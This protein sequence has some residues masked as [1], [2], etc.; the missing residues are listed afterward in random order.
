M[1]TTK[2]RSTNFGSLERYDNAL[3]GVASLAERYFA[4]D[5]IDIS[6]LPGIGRRRAR[7]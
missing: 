6:A 2:S 5:P 3:V 7:L 4:D 1:A